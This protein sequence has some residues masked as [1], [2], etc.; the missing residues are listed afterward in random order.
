MANNFV[1]YASLISIA[2]NSM[3]AR[4][5]SISYHRNELKEARNYYSSLVIGN[6][7]IVGLLIIPAI[8]CISKLE[9]LINVEE[10]NVLDVKLLFSFVFIN[11]FITQ[12]SSVFYIAMYVMN[13]LF[14]QN[15]INLVKAIFNMITILV[16]F[17]YLPPKIFYVSFIGAFLGLCTIPFYYKIK[18]KLL[19]S[20]TFD[21]KYFNIKYTF[22]MIKSGMWNTINQCGNVLMT[23]LDLL[24]ANLLVNS[25]QMG[26]LAAAKTIPNYMIQLAGMLNNNFQPSLTIAYATKGRREMLK[27]LRISMKISSVFMSIPIITFCVFGVEFYRLWMPTLDERQLTILSLLTCI[28]FI[29][30][31]G[32]Q[33][34]YNVFTTT[35]NLKVNSITFLLTGAANFIIVYA[36]LLKTDLGVYAIAGVSSIL[37]II[38]NLCVTVPYTAHLLKLK[39]YVFYADVAMSMLCCGIAAGISFAVKYFIAINGWATLFVAVIIACSLSLLIQIMILL[40]R[41][42]R[43]VLVAKFMGGR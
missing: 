40:T 38:R 6:M 19:N 11:F 13:K 10:T 35:D 33:T 3:A 32:P 8:L 43:Q 28:A 24:L 30:F 26:A 9:M 31:A 25:S 7:I 42:E 17:N 20:I 36:L 15:L 23:G 39:W 2:L 12:I 37:S 29:P 41:Q 16:V 4:F 21:F 22:I 14:W 5:I 18:K 1:T 34:L 27:Q